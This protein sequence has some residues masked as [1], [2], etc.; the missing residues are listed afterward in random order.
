MRPLGSVSASFDN[1]QNDNFTRADNA[2]GLGTSSRGLLWSADSGLWQVNTNQAYTTDSTAGYTVSTASIG[3]TDVTETV[4]AL[5]TA[6]GGGIGVVFWRSAA[7]S[8]WAAL[9]NTTSSSV[10]NCTGGSTLFCSD[11]TNTC[12]PGGCGSGCSSGFYSSASNCTG[13]GTATC[14]DSVNTCTPAGCGGGCTVSS[15]G[16]VACGS[17]GNCQSNGT[18]AGPGSCVPAGAGTCGTGCT[19]FTAVQGASSGTKSIPCGACGTGSVFLTAGQTGHCTCCVTTVVTTYTRSCN[20]GGTTYTRSCN[21][22][23]ST[24]TY[25]SNVNLISSVSGVVT[26]QYIGAV[27]SSTSSRPVIKSMKVTTVGTT[28]TA[29]AYSDT[30]LT[31]QMGSD[32][33][34]TPASPTRGPGVGIIRGPGGDLTESRIA[35][36]TS[37]GQ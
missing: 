26:T 23:G 18:G 12:T 30:G 29:K 11:S 14:T 36:F 20:T 34:Y 33:V 8:W 3:S 6:T 10:G 4:V 17:A 24:T 1:E 16:G 37:S 15:N 19:N 7:N 32:V 21:S 31:T 25:T 9:S 13:G 27:A 2:T 22:G 35:G 28:I 5:S